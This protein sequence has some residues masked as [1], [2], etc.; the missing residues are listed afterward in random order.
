MEL[1][2]AR[3]NTTAYVPLP[4][5]GLQNYVLPHPELYDLSADPGESYDVGPKYPDVV[6][7]MTAKIAELI[8]TFP[9]PVKSAYKLA[10]ER[11]ADPNTPIGA[12]PRAKPKM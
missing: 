6:A 11:V 8:T 5:G 2:L 9:E 1:Y 10:R 12:W 7:R 3:Y 4:L